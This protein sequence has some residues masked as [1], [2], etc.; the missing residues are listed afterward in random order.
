MGG[1]AGRVRGRGQGAPFLRGATHALGSGCGGWRLREGT[2]GGDVASAG[3]PSPHARQG[4]PRRSIWP[5]STIRGAVVRRAESALLQQKQPLLRAA[6]AAP[7]PPAP[8]REQQ[9][10]ALPGRAA[11]P[12]NGSDIRMECA[13]DTQDCRRKLP[14][15]PQLTSRSPCVRLSSASRAANDAAVERAE[16]LSCRSAARS[17]SRSAVSSLTRRRSESSRAASCGEEERGWRR[18]RPPP[19]AP[20]PHVFVLRAKLRLEV[21]HARA[22]VLE[23]LH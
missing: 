18:L 19:P 20:P 22:Q 6:R 2:E 14:P 21:P 5:G 11:P 1:A 16:S 4:V 9:R 15:P 23:L 8:R 7:A 10:R 17:P 3:S 13:L 12:A